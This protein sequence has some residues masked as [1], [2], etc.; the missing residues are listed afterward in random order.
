VSNEI[1]DKLERIG[2]VAIVTYFRILSWHLAEGTENNEKSQNILFTA[3]MIRKLTY[4]CVCVFLR[5][6]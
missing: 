3:E 5:R 6:Y 4:S 2:K 1:R